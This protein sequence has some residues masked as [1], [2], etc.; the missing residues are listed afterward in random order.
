MN[1]KVIDVKTTYPENAGSV[2][3]SSDGFTKIVAVEID[4]IKYESGRQDKEVRV[5]VLQMYS[6]LKPKV[7]G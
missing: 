4:T 3:I 1:D 5:P 2:Q 7:I 6:N